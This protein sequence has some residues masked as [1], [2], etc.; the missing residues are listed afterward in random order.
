MASWP[1]GQSYCAHGDIGQAIG[2]NRALGA[3]NTYSIFQ[4]V[5][6]SECQE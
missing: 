1:S 5:A 6:Q 2:Y 3:Y 4:R